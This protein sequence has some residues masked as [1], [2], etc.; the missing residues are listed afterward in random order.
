MANPLDNPILVDGTMV[1]NE[2]LGA[3][4]KSTLN[5]Y[6]PSYYVTL[7]SWSD[8][9]GV[10]V[11][12]ENNST[13][14]PEEIIDNYSIVDSTV[15]KLKLYAEELLKNLS[16]KLLE[17]SWAIPDIYRIEFIPVFKPNSVYIL[18]SEKDNIEEFSIITKVSLGKAGYK[19]I[20]KFDKDDIDSGINELKEKLNLLFNGVILFL[21]SGISAKE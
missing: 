9:L 1:L 4:A 8:T 21:V 17:F 13:L 2:T 15:D 16:D 18:F 11:E 10:I 12:D 14:E 3:Y 20:T 7:G 6:N 5:A 19:F